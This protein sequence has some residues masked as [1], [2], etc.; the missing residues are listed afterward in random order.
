MKNLP[1]FVS[2]FLAVAPLAAPADEPAAAP[3][4]KPATPVFGAGL[5]LADLTFSPGIALPGWS[6]KGA[7]GGMKADAD[8]W[9]TFFV[10]TGKDASFPTLKGRVRFSAADGAVHAEWHVVPDADALLLETF[11]GAQVPGSAIGGGTAVV[12]GKSIP[13]TLDGAK[14]HLFRGATSR[15]SLVARDG[16]ELL[17]V[18][19]A[20]PTRILLQDGA[21]WGGDTLTIRLFLA[22]GALKAGAEYALDAEFSMPATGPL[23]LG[24]GKPVRIVAGADWLPIDED[25]WIEPG[26]ALDFTQVLPHHAPAG[27][28]GRVVAVGDH[29]EFADLPGIPQRFY[30]VNI[31]GDANVPSTPE[32][33]DRFAAQ[34]ARVGY[35]TLRIHHHERNLV[36]KNAQWHEGIDDTQPDPERMALFDNLVAACVE[37]GIYL[38]T[39]LFVSRSHVT[40]WRSLGIDRDGCISNTGHFKVLCA[41]WEPAYSNLLAWSRAFL[42]HVNPITGRSLAEEPALATLALVNEGN[43]GNWGSAFLRDVPGV[44]EAWETWQIAHPDIVATV[45]GGAGEPS[46][47][48][49]PIPDDIKA[50]GDTPAG[51][52]AGAFAMFLA[53][54]EALLANR[55]RAFLRDELHCD[56]PISSLSSWYNPVQYQLVRKECFDYVDDHFYV[57]HPTFLDKSWSLPSR[58]PNTNPMAGRS[59]GAKTVEWRRLMDKPFCLTEWNYSGPGRFRG[60]GGI[61]TGALGALQNWSGMWRFA[62]SHGRGGVETPE[63]KTMGYFDMSGDPLGLAAERAALCLFLRRDLPELTA[64]YPL[65]LDEDALHDPR[66][67]APSCEVPAALWTGWHAKVGSVVKPHAE[68]QGG[69]SHAEFAKSAEV[70]HALLSTSATQAEADMALLG[71]SEAGAGAV[72]IDPATGTFLLDTPRTAGGFAESGAHTAGPLRFDLGEF[73]GGEAADLQPRSGNLS[74][75]AALKMSATPATVWVSSL[76]GEPVATSSRLLLT[77]LTDVQNSGIE[78]ADPAL[79]ILLK[80]GSLPHLMR[81]GSAEIE[82]SFQGG[83]AVDLK[84]EGQLKGGEA[85]DLIGGKPAPRV[86]RLAPSGRRLGEVPA[87]YDAAAGVLRFTARTDLDP[88]TATY[89]YE[90]V[91]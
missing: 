43:L 8:G 19:F 45:L 10:R 23:A 80:W 91:R 33:C 56:V 87:T 24:E 90:I 78:Y 15:L 83:E 26:S 63:K 17:R 6:F 38:T 58:C 34:L 88:S 30:G 89:L 42:T 14:P 32:A 65:V 70:P 77:H 46:P 9:R 3:A 69:V 67:G 48:R 81:R 27:K 49:L 59:A 44:Q 1:R 12:D 82:L 60:V 31:C 41:F 64:T 71:A 52:L 51:R 75:E 28:F 22:E 86:F 11:V 37:H 7:A 47:D 66:T 35:N 68:R 13:V 74:G 84:A 21:H 73:N 16:G 29:F 53:E 79:T 5:S 54:R 20:K 18:N 4:A 40:T 62:W 2:A 55:L 36:S 61:A 39:D 50:S 57:D 72:R 76:D 85:A 25:P